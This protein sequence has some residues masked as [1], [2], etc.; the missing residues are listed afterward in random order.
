MEI[1]VPNLDCDIA[2]PFCRNKKKNNL[3]KLEGDKYAVECS[4]CEAQGPKA[5][6]EK[7]ALWYWIKGK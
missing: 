2:C 5:F 7:G 6:S 4:K 1:V 3:V